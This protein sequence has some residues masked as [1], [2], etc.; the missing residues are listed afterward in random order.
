MLRNY[1]DAGNPTSAAGARA[2]QPR[3]DADPM[4]KLQEQWSKVLT[5]CYEL[6]AEGKRCVHEEDPLKRFDCTRC[7]YREA[8]SFC[9]ANVFLKRV[10]SL[11]AEHLANKRIERARA[12]GAEDSTGDDADSDTEEQTPAPL[13]TEDQIEDFKAQGVAYEIETPL[14]AEHVWLVPERTGKKRLEFTPEEI[15]FMAQT[16]QTLEGS[17]VEICRGPGH[18]EQGDSE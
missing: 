11:V 16:A 12:T 2:D 10:V 17:L 7:E 1:L 6:Y 9:Q 8:G 15:H 5:R 3:D 14:C 18:Q 4:R 13:L